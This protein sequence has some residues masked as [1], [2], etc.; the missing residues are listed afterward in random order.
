MNKESECE[1]AH[2]VSCIQAYCRSLKG[3]LAEIQSQAENQFVANLIKTK[4]R[5]YGTGAAWPFN[6][7][8]EALIIRF[9]IM[10]NILY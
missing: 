8:K 6:V 1:K 7:L 10:I 2:V 4:T 9:Y 3:Y 5:K